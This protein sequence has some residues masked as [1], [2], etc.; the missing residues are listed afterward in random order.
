[1]IRVDIPTVSIYPEEPYK[2]V[3]KEV[4]YEIMNEIDKLI[5][6]KIEQEET[7]RKNNISYG[8]KVLNRQFRH[9]PSIEENKAKKLQKGL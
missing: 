1:M 5:K 7:Y 2:K 4:C 6:N 9:I 8:V 3:K